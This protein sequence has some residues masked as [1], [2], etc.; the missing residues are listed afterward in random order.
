MKFD[1]LFRGSMP[2]NVHLPKI[3]SPLQFAAET[4]NITKNFT[5]GIFTRVNLR[6]N[7]GTQDNWSFT[8]TLKMTEN[9]PIILP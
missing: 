8:V 7:K 4:W 5:C 3:S 9:H 6:K 2:K 1:Q